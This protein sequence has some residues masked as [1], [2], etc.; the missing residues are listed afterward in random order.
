MINQS[1]QIGLSMLELLVVFVIVSL[2]STLLMQSLG[3]G[4]SLFERVSSRGQ[5]V[6]KEVLVREWF[7]IVNQS[8]VAKVHQDGPS[9]VGDTLSFRA[10]TLNPLLTG[11]GIAQTVSWSIERG[12]LIY[13]EAGQNLEIVNLPQGSRLQYQNHN[14][15][16][17]DHWPVGEE[18]QRL[19]QSVA[20][21][22]G[23][24]FPVLAV[25]RVRS[26][27]DFLLEESR[28]ERE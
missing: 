5:S 23:S 9:L 1:K 28:R 17:F 25:L 2:V 20:V 19:P 8:L 14:G 12:V 15:R 4:L 27:P 16:W 6:Q 24:E 11:P 26:N 22:T 10:S 13:K 3:F 21:D 7:R 18:T